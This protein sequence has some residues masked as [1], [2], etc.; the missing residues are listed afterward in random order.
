MALTS[1]T[2]NDKPLATE[3]PVSLSTATGAF[4]VEGASA[5]TT[6]QSRQGLSSWRWS[7]SIFVVFMTSLI[8]GM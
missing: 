2:M 5:G 4:T 7:G 3:P 1:G 8:H 6:A